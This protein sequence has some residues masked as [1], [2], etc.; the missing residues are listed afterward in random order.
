MISNMILL[1]YPLYS[2]ISVVIAY[3]KHEIEYLQEF[4]YLPKPT[5]DVAA[6][7]SETMIEEAIRE[8]QLY[9]NIPVTGKFDT[10]TEELL[11]RKRCGL[12]DRPIQVLREK[13]FALMGPKWTKQIITYSVDNPSRSIPNLGA[14]RREI[15]EAINSWQHILPMQFYEVRPEAEADVKIR[16]AVG[17]HGDPY[18]FDGNGRILAHAFP[19]G[20]GIGGDI[21]LDDD[22]R[23]TVALTGDPYRQQVSLRSIV[24]HEFGHSIGLSH[25]HQEDSIMYAFYQYD[26]TP[27]LSYD[28]LLAVRTLYGGR[29]YHP[30][31]P[32]VAPQ[33]HSSTTERPSLLPEGPERPTDRFPTIHPELPVPEPDPC[34]SEYDA[35]ASIRQE[36]FVFKD[37]WFWRIRQ[38]G[39]LSQSPRHINTLWREVSWPIDAAVESDHQI[40]L[41]ADIYIFNGQHLISKKLLT[42]LGLPASIEHIRLVYTW[43]YWTERPMYIWTK[44]EFWRVDKK[45]ERVEIGYPRKIATTWHG[46]PEEASAAVTYNNDLYFFNGKAAYKFHTINM[47][48]ASP[49]NASQ[50]WYFCPVAMKISSNGNAAHISSLSNFIVIVVITTIFSFEHKW[51]I[52]LQ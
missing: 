9:G 30:E 47:T 49:I 46:I 25:S 52:I 38:D 18:R 14:I 22:E 8:L 17:D 16:F 26:L 27:K 13:R 40:Y 45:T 33:P 41:F 7:F 1:T 21:H 44:D 36:I 4:G 42:D 29:D 32:T 6:M 20:E 2:I 35:V 51:P 5:Q 10:A 15:N 12:S 19:P 48:A 28:D 24:M 11:S 37:R 31:K 3:N 50:L 34:K 23:W 39:T 43:N